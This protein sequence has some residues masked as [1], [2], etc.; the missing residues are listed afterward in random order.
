[1]SKLKTKLKTVLFVDTLALGTMYAINNTISSSALLKNI[2]KP[3][4]G[5]YYNWKMGKIFYKTMGSGAPL[6]LIHDLDVFS[7]GYE[8]NLMLE[9]L[10][11]DH[12]L[13]IMDLLGCGRSEKPGITYTNYLYVQLL[14]DFINDVIGEKTDV[15]VT[16]LSS[17]FVVMTALSNSDLIGK[18]TMINPP[19]LNR[20]D[21][22]PDKKSKI[23]RT[24]MSIPIIGTS[25]Y[26]IKTSRQNIEYLITEK[27]VYNPFR[28]PSKHIDAYYEA[29]HYGRGSGK[30]LMASLDGFY[31][32]LNISRALSK[33]ENEITI[34]YGDKL[35][36]EK[37]I[38]HGYRKLNSKISTVSIAGTK[39]IPQLEKPEEV[40]SRI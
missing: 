35:E 2:L 5:K 39:M 1:M 4:S 24:I 15:A 34:I 22:I 7:S 29:A 3:K 19:S 37:E 11:K 32:N 23:I 33:L 30:Y 31:L 40:A 17:S 20:L 10:K 13:Y 27:Y 36:N 6:L 16:G 25:I 8:W 12:T 21:Q 26:H 9:S 14:T 38:V 28:T 18:I